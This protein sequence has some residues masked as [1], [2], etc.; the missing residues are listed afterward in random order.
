MGDDIPHDQY[1]CKTLELHTDVNRIWPPHETQLQRVVRL[2]HLRGKRPLAPQCVRRGQLG[3]PCSRAAEYWPLVMDVAR[4]N[5]VKRIIR[6]SQIMGRSGEGEMPGAQI[7]YPCMQCADIFFLKARPP[8]SPA[9]RAVRFLFVGCC[10]ACRERCDQSTPGLDHNHQARRTS[11]DE[12]SVSER[13]LIRDG[14]VDLAPAMWGVRRQ[15]S[16]SW[17]WISAR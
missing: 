17:A 3:A 6:C 13:N 7:F 9:L 4:R 1:S 10:T 15:T 14:G 8:F 16:A 2:F 5:T 12:S 11:S